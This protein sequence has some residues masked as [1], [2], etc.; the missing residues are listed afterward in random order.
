[1]PLAPPIKIPLY[2]AFVIICAHMAVAAWSR[3]V[4]PV[5]EPPGPKYSFSPFYSRTSFE[6]ITKSGWAD[7][8][9]I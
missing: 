4:T 5:S 3:L 7:T 2:K 9:V 1:M 6:G 8:E